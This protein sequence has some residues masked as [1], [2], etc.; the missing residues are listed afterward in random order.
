M[1][2]YGVAW[3][4]LSYALRLHCPHCRSPVC[5]RIERTFFPHGR[6][7]GRGGCD[8]SSQY[9]DKGGIHH[10]NAN[11]PTSQTADRDPPTLIRGSGVS[12]QQTPRAR[13]ERTR[14]GHEHPRSGGPLP[15]AL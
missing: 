9:T 15:Y 14:Q 2:V 13:T 4:G 5:F 6:D 8:S 12:F 1:C 7:A 3:M 10:P 11:P